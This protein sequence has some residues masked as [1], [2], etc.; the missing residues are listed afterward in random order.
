MP[1]GIKSSKAK[2]M[3]CLIQNLMKPLFENHMSQILS[4]EFS[5]EMM[6][7]WSKDDKLTSMEGEYRET[8]FEKLLQQ[9]VVMRRLNISEMEPCSWHS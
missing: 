2:S 3:N 6:K 7:D 4:G 1:K 8:S 5:R 9:Q